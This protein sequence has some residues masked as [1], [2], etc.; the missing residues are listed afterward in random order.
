MLGLIVVIGVFI[1]FEIFLLVCI[2][3]KYYLLWENLANVMLLDYFGVLLAMLLFLFLFLLF[4]GLFWSLVF[5]GLVNVSLGVFI[6]FY[7]VGWLLWLLVCGMFGVVLGIS[8]VFGIL[9]Y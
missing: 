5:F 9:F 8:L 6:L 3:K 2:M 7:F 4:F 1:G